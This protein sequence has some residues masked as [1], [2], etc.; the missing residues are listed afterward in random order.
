MKGYYREHG[1]T[2]IVFLSAT[3]KENMDDF[4]KALYEAVKKKHLMIYPNYL[5]GENPAVAWE[6][7]PVES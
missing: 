3:T 5:G 6:N 7:L 1:F 2:D 4:K